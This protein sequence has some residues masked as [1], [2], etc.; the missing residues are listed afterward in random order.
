M[1]A[2][3]CVLVSTV[4]QNESAQTPSLDGR[5]IMALEDS[6]GQKYCGGHFWKI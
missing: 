3:K 2:F 5:S 6:V 4:Q 1:V